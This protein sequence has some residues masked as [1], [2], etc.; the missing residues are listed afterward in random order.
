MFPI[1]IDGTPAGC[2]TSKQ[3]RDLPRE[4]WDQHNVHD[5][6]TPC[7]TENAIPPNMDAIKALSIMNRTGNSRLMVA[8]G[9]HLVGI[10]SLKDMLAFLDLKLDLEGG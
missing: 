2:I 6:L 4:H 5:I 7:S 8:N 9:N 3:G 10:I 1:V